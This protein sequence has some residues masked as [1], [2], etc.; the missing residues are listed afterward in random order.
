[1]MSDG[2]TESGFD[3]IGVETEVWKDGSAQELAEHLADYAQRR[4]DNDHGDDITVMVGIIE[5]AI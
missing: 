2:A 4:L 3:W 5:K 1:M